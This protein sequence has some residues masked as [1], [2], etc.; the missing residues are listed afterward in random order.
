MQ[1]EGSLQS[2]CIFFMVRNL[3]SFDPLY[4]LYSGSIETEMDS[5]FLSKAKEFN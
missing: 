1:A 5:K 4:Y 2:E 3:Q